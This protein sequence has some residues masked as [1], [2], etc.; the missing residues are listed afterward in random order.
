MEHLLETGQSTQQLARSGTPI[1]GATNSPSSPM[2]LEPCGAKL[3]TAE[4]SA[5]LLL[6]APTGMREAERKSWLAVARKTLSGMPADLL[7]QGCAAA[8][9]QADHPSKI[10]PCIFREVGYR[11]ED[12]KR[13]AAR[14][15]QEEREAAIAKL[16]KPERPPIPKDETRQ[17]IREA[18]AHMS[19]NA[20]GE[21][22]R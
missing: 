10:V 4:L 11:W 8:R 20:G 15:E 19:V 2:S 12:R 3:G 6:V 1:L 13:W 5:C 9:R 17:L 7:Q 14:R 18:C 16:P 22:A 21:N